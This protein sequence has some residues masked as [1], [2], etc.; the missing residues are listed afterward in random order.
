MDKQVLKNKE[1]SFSCSGER[2][3]AEDSRFF[4]FYD[5]QSQGKALRLDCDYEFLCFLLVT[6]AKIRALQASKNSKTR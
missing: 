1:H 2:Y 5:F 3:K 6:R 4:Q